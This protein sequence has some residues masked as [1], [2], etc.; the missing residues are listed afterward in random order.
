MPVLDLIHASA[1]YTDSGYNS[2]SSE[3]YRLSIQLRLDGF[4]FAIIDPENMQLLRLQDFRL[5]DKPQNSLSEKWAHVHEYFLEYINQKHFT[6][7]QYKKV[8]ITLDHKEY[9]LMPNSLILNSNE[10]DQLQFGQK[11]AYPFN[12]FI[13][14]IPGKD[15]QLISAIYKPLHF[16][17]QDNFNN[18]SLQH[19]GHVLQNEVFKRH[20]NTSK[21]RG[22]Y[23]YVSMH[24]MNIVAIDEDR[25]LLNNSY[26]FSSKEDFVYFILLAYDQLKLN[27]EEDPIYFLGDISKSSPIYQICWQYVRHI[28]FIN[29]T[30]GITTSSAF[31][32]VA[33]HQYFILIQS[34]LCE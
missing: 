33:I 15:Y 26:S 20:R 29:Q 1:E 18:F 4:S 8:I 34:A 31:D 25:L 30:S 24:D 21:S 11:I 16:T 23:V 9:T 32:Q 3:K 5:I 2:D 27:A 13:N 19:V 28:H 12:V 7:H 10:K 6:S 17:L 22:L 14:T